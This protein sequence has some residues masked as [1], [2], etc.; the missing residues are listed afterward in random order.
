[1]GSGQTAKYARVF[2]VDVG[3]QAQ[4][5]SLLRFTDYFL[6]FS[7]GM[8][9]ISVLGSIFEP[10]MGGVV[11]V[12]IGIVISILL[13]YAG[14]TGFR[15]VGVLSPR[16]WKQYRVI[17]RVLSVVGL[18]VLLV[19]VGIL[20]YSAPDSSSPEFFNALVFIFCG[21]WCLVM[22][23][24]SLR[25]LRKLSNEHVSPFGLGIS[26]IIERVEHQADAAGIDVASLPRLN[27]KKGYIY[28]T[29]AA[30]ILLSWAL[31][32][33]GAVSKKPG[34]ESRM[35]SAVLAL[36]G[37]FAFRARRYFQVNADKLI[38][39]D[40]RQPVLFL[41]SFDDDEKLQYANAHKSFL[42]FSLETR[43]TR[44]FLGFGPFVAIGSPK[45]KLP[46]VGA[47]RVLLPDDQ[48]QQRVLGWMLQ[49]QL[50]VMYAGKT[51]WVNWELRQVLRGPGAER[52][53]MLFP[54]MKGWW[55]SRIRADLKQRYELL[56]VAF[57]GTP[58]EEELAAWTDLE[59][60]RG[61][62]FN[63]DGS[64]VI[65]R[66]QSANRDA[67]HLAAV[68]GHYVLLERLRIPEELVRPL[69]AA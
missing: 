32:P 68:V 14:Y 28:A 53:L 15:H 25:A 48:W 67:Y 27:K 65:I 29:I 16:V 63:K 38:E 31:M 44:H 49:S 57:K 1:M 55:P 46:Q 4:A 3:K 58:W 51:P 6:V 66:S 9:S 61:I 7:C 52:L 34:E 40:K 50:I 36:G 23:P 18:L 60:L 20:A 8:M 33:T 37:F 22:C 26:E 56:K 41:R 47:A 42:D 30:A 35:T 24:L 5:L 21:S 62:V 45:E 10:D 11:D 54:E 43:L 64:A 17:M 39:H 69:K 12:F 13:A 59:G 19:G 2:E